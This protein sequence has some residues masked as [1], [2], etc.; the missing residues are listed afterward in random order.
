MIAG[1]P[2]SINNNT[3]GSGTIPPESVLKDGDELELENKGSVSV[4][5]ELSDQMV[6]VTS[7]NL[8]NVSPVTF[9]TTFSL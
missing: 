7:G 3:V 6:G 9:A 8:V 2:S 1:K 4:F 5:K